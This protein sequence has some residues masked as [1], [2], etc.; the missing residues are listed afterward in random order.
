[1]SEPNVMPPTFRRRPEWE[2]HDATWLVWPHCADTWPGLVLADA[3][4]PA[5]VAMI[6]ALR[7]GETVRVVVQSD[8]HAAAVG[9]RLAAAG[10]ESAVDARGADGPAVRLH[11]WPTDDEWVRDFGA[12]VV[13]DAG[14]RRLATDWQ[15]NAWG[16]KYPRTERNNT[17]PAAMAEAHG[18]DRRAFDVVLEGGSV[19]VD[20]T[21]L[22][23]TTESC[24]LNP[25]RN[26]GLD[27]A[28]VE[29]LLADGLGVSETIWLGD[30]IAGDDTDGHV[31]DFARFVAPR[32]V[33][34]AQEPD[35]DDANHAP[36]AEAAARLRAWR[37]ADGRGL[38]VHT[39]P[40]PPALWHATADGSERLPASYANFLI[41]NAAVLMPA[42]GAPRDE[43]A[44]EILERLVGRP[45]ARIP[46]RSLVWGLG[47]CH[48]LSQDVVA[49]L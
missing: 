14:G 4:E 42:F 37:G 1:M 22:G 10:I 18:L 27:R 32:T 28:G 8:A 35:P 2:P 11:V 31:D 13:K 16:G 46:A 15:F 38:T 24:L 45:V 3:V 20:G 23:L 47:A 5:Y 33:V 19:D 34:V 30:G 9:A 25:N 40:M 6:D 36:L 17:V 7:P 41:G 44:A 21:G 29:A 39:L 49:G 48:C 43:E 26:P 12:L